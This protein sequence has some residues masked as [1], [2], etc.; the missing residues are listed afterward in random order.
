MNEHQIYSKVQ[1]NSPHSL[2]SERTKLYHV[3]EIRLVN[4]SQPL[5]LISFIKD[6]RK[7]SSILMK[8]RPGLQ[9]DTEF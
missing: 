1:P 7:Y 8:S 4:L 2:L 3:F 5:P 9:D 6:F